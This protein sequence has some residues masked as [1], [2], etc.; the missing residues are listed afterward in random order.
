MRVFRP[1][2]AAAIDGQGCERP[3]TGRF[4]RDAEPLFRIAESGN[5]PLAEGGRLNHDTVAVAI[6][7]ATLAPVNGLIP[8]SASKDTLRAD[9]ASE[10]Q[11]RT[12]I[13]LALKENRR[14]D[15]DDRFGAKVLSTLVEP[16]WDS[17][18]EACVAA[19]RRQ[20]EGFLAQFDFAMENDVA[21]G[22]LVAV[23]YAAGYAAHG[24]AE[25][26]Q[27]MRGLLRLLPFVI[28]IGMPEGTGRKWLVLVE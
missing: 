18:G 12:F 8:V 14:Q 2:I 4:M 3:L 15:F 26:Y 19:L 11:Y 28:P 16:L 23:A 17:F 10:R 21:Y 25:D 24:A 5:Y 20:H 1:D 27:R 13:S 22:P 7:S 9:H 6:A